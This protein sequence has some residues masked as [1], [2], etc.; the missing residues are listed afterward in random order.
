MRLAM[1]VTSATGLTTLVMKTMLEMYTM[2]TTA[3]SRATVMPIPVSYTHPTL[4]TTP[5]V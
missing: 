3:T 4:P 2:A 5:Y 1:P